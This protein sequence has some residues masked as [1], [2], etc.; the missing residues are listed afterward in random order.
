[1]KKRLIKCTLE[2]IKADMESDKP[3]TTALWRCRLWQDRV[4]LRA[5]FKGN[6]WKASGFMPTTILADNIT[7][8]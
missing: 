8:T 3:W 7:V 5:A 4:A 1:M 2:E 6:G